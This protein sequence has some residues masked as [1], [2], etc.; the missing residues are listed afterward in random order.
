MKLT[1]AQIRA[2]KYVANFARSEDVVIDTDQHKTFIRGADVAIKIL[3]AEKAEENKAKRVAKKTPAAKAEQVVAQ[4]PQAQAGYLLSLI[5]AFADSTTVANRPK[6]PEIMSGAQRQSNEHAAN[7][8]TLI[9]KF[10][11]EHLVGEK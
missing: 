10:V 5:R 4:S 6:R 1:A 2:L 8:Y 7:A 3:E 11:R 9:L